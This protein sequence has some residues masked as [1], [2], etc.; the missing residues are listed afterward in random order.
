VLLQ[1]ENWL[2]TP[3]SE[4]SHATMAEY[5]YQS[6]LSILFVTRTDHAHG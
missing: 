5:F 2:S 4:A 6:F 1:Y 3:S